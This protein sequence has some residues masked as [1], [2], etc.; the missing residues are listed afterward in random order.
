MSRVTKFAA[1][2][3]GPAARVAGFMAH[4]RANGLRLGAGETTVALNALSAMNAYSP[5]ECR[6][7]LRPICTGCKE[8]V[9]QFDDLFDAY[10]MDMGR[11][12]TRAVP[13]LQSKGNNDVHSS[14][15][16]T[17]DAGAAR[18]MQQHPMA[19]MARPKAMGKAS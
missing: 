8:D 12:R 1:Q 5:D 4:L 7:A 14:R 15:D 9:D 19:V 17:G 16:A 2:D 18:A 6:N 3:A 13:K 11:V 10:W